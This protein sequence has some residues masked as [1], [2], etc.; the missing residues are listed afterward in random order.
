MLQ[1]K[2]IDSAGKEWACQRIVGL[3]S[4]GALRCFF[5]Y[6][7]RNAVTARDSYTLRRRDE[8]INILRQVYIFTALGENSK[9]LQTKIVDC[10]NRIRRFI[11]T[12]DSFRS[13]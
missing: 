7:K 4:N 5:D 12:K 10:D 13:W 3:E 2:I 1:E 11:V 8:C 6:H 9:Y